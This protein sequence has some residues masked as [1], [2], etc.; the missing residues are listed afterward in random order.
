LDPRDGT[1]L[2]SLE[3]DATLYQP[4]VVPDAAIYF[5]ADEGTLHAVEPSGGNALWSF[6]GANLRNRPAVGADGSLC[7]SSFDQDNELYA[8]SNAPDA[9][10]EAT[11]CVPCAIGCLSGSALGRC[12]PDGSA[13]ASFQPCAFNQTCK[14]GACVD[15]APGKT[16]TCDGQTVVSFDGCGRET[17]VE[18]CGTSSSCSG[19]EC[20][21]VPCSL[22]YCMAEDAFIYSC[23]TPE[24][25]QAT[26]IGE[27]GEGNMTYSETVTAYDNGHVVTCGLPDVWQESGYCSDDTGASCDW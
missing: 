17:V 7:V 24:F 2:W 5:V 21:D 8:L 10:E 27:D 1:V 16:R 9:V 18:T 15:C 12:L 11:A 26:E 13:Y 6:K 19:G 4:V 20:G 3:V 25:S 23:S 22:S 14:R